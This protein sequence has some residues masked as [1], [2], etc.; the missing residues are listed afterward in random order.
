[1]VCVCV[2]ASKNAFLLSNT[3]AEMRGREPKSIHSPRCMRV[4]CYVHVVVFFSPCI[5]LRRA[6][7]F[8]VAAPCRAPRF[9]MIFSGFDVR[10]MAFA[11]ARTRTLEIISTAPSLFYG[12]ARGRAADDLRAPRCVR[13]CARVC[14]SAALIQS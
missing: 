4:C 5:L 9:K 6:G 3:R 8:L 13:P 1:M 10:L 11:R 2:C 7:A 14:A 12:L